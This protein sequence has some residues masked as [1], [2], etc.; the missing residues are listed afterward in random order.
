MEILFYLVGPLLVVIGIL[1]LVKKR[2]FYKASA[3]VEG[4]VNQIRTGPA[5]RNR[6][7]YYPVVGYFDESSSKE[8]IYESNTAYERSKFKIGDRVELRYL[9]DGLKKQL[10]LN[11]WSGIWGLSFMLIL[12]GIIFCII[13]YVLLFIA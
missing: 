10:C 11:N 13:D 8:E 5:S 9:N 1:T 4:T 12:F 6:T 2:K 3:V 7:A